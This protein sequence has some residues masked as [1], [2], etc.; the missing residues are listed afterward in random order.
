M[1]KHVKRLLTLFIEFLYRSKKIIKFL[2]RS[3]KTILFVLVVATITIALSATISIWLSRVNHLYIPSVGNVKTLGVEAY[4]GDIIDSGN[5]QYIDWGT[6]YP[7]G[8]TYRSFYIRS[9]S[10]IKTTFNLETA[11]W[12]YWDSA[13]NNVTGSN[14]NYLNLDWNYTDTPISPGDEIYVTLTLQASASDSFI[15]YLIANDV[16]GFSFD[17]CIYG[18]DQ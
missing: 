3:K 8:L 18:S 1:E 17:I 2:Y 14:N 5:E 12:T 16:T 11:N 15:S 4:E 13:G 10:N 6:V 7:G 9:K